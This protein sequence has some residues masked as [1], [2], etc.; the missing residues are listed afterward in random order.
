MTA[1]KEIQAEVIKVQALQNDESKEL[2]DKNLESVAGGCYLCS[3]DS[4]YS[5][6]QFPQTGTEYSDIVYNHLKESTGTFLV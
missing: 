2:S 1:K 5:R 6:M 3:D 4:S